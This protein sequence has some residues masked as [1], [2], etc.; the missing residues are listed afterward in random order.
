MIELPHRR[1]D[2]GGPTVSKHL[3]ALCALMLEDKWLTLISYISGIASKYGV[4][5]P[6]R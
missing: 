2:N 4:K 5:M 1:S 6:S 3:P